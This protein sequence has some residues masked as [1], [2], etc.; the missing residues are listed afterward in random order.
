MPESPIS[1]EM[2]ADDPTLP[3]KERQAPNYAPKGTQI[4]VAT[5]TDPRMG[6]VRCGAS[7]RKSVE[8]VRRRA[9]E[10]RGRSRVFEG[11]FQNFERVFRVFITIRHF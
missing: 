8:C 10:W 9:Q 11:V 2:P 7:S 4:Q 6:W 5:P 1:K 3:E